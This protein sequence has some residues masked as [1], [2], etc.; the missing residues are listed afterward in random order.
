MLRLAVALCALARAAEDY[1]DYVLVEEHHHVVP[2]VLEAV[3]SGK[4]AAGATL[5][6]FDSHHDGG[7]PEKL[8]TESE[9]H[10]ALLEHVHINNFLL[11]LAWK[12]A[13][14]HVVFVEPPWSVQC[15]KLH[16]VT[17]EL[18]VGL[19]EPG[20]AA[21][22]AVAGDASLMDGFFDAGQKVEDHGDLHLP[23]ALR[24]TVV[25]LEDAA[26][27]LPGLVGARDVV[28]DV[29]LDAFGTTSPGALTLRT[30]I[31][32]PDLRRLYRLAHDLCV[33]DGGHDF[34]RAPPADCARE[35][36]KLDGP[37]PLHHN[38]LAGAAIDAFK[39][40]GFNLKHDAARL[41]KI[42]EIVRLREAALVGLEERHGNVRNK[43]AGF[44]DQPYETNPAVVD[45]A[46]RAF[47]AV[48]R[49]LPR[50]E[51]VTLVRSPFYAPAETLGTVECH[52]AD[53]LVELYGRGGV[54]RHHAGVDVDRV[55]CAARHPSTS[56]ADA[57]VLDHVDR[58]K[59]HEESV[60]A[61]FAFDGELRDDSR[62][63]TVQFANDGREDVA[64]FW[65][66]TKLAELGPGRHQGFH[67][68]DREPWTFRSADGAT[69]LL[70]L[71]VDAR[72]GAQQRYSSTRGLVPFD[73]T[74]VKL[75][76]VAP[77]RRA[78]APDDD[79]DDGAAAG[80]PAYYY[81]GTADEA[82]LRVHFDTGNGEVFFRQLNYGQTL[83]VDTFHGHVWHIYEGGD[84]LNTITVDAANGREQSFG[85]EEL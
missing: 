10:D 25:A 42:A 69:K 18:R 67:T 48:A 29:D 64:V 68:L 45:G 58:R 28:L 12:G 17:M 51:V 78:S 75:S 32:I 44:L 59:L 79:D 66:E 62:D 71:V 30:A 19:D 14:E 84:R 83:K 55:H 72:D 49:L 7:L 50:P 52:A 4:L 15:V 35:P 2:F 27:V 8:W 43:V 24:Y 60:D 11:A 5:V 85:A 57:G 56:V 36:T 70:S 6:H 65:R 73:E 23:Q 54:L 22:V 74:P 61:L 82:E 21:R 40:R 39:D 1:P 47:S 20:G 76:V 38:F 3:A 33:F 16:N 63:V 46:I 34:S 13:V 80:E 81:R 53:A 77:A 41:G 26:A 9:T 31:P 37:A